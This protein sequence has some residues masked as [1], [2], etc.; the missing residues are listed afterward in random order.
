MSSGMTNYRIGPKFDHSY[1]A[2][3]GRGMEN[4]SILTV[5]QNR[6]ESTTS[7]QS[8][9]ANSKPYIHKNIA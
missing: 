7:L 2:K 5:H 6:R 9:T 3:E 1:L 4:V 8:Y